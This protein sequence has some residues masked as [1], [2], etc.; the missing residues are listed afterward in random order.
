M[1]LLSFLV[2]VGMRG[3]QMPGGGIYFGSELHGP[4]FGV[5]N[6]G[7]KPI[8]NISRRMSAISIEIA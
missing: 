1:F 2:I 5:D 6:C 8:A 4:I 3:E 7:Q